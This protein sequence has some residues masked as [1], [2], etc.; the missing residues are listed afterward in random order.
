M[1]KRRHHLIPMFST[2][3]TATVSVALV[4]FILG[5]ASI[6]GIATHRVT[7]TIKENIGFVVL[8]NEDV[9]ASDIAAVKNQLKAHPGVAKCEYS[10]PE[11]VLERWQ[12][13]VGEGEDI[14]MLADV[15]PFVGEMDVHVT[16][17][18]ALSDS[19]NVIIAPLILMPQISDIKVHTEMIGRINSTLR[20]VTLG[21]FIVAVALLVISFVLIFNTVRLS[22]YARRFIIH[23]MKLVGATP[24]FIRRPFLV[25]NVVNGIVAS[26]IAIAGLSLLVYYC[27]ALDLSVASVLDWSILAPV[28]AGVV[29]VGVLLCLVASIFATNRYLRLS[30]DEMFK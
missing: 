28:F 12:K 25:D 29:I 5:I 16:S 10:S 7:E 30:Y 19:I 14:C 2:R 4:L 22:V 23:T 15:N 1:A 3:A 20:S 8:F 11:V 18:Y 13:M 9:T 26:M 6:V 17:K 27:R 21:L 24:G